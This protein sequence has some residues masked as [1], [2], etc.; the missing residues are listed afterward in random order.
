MVL[1]IMEREADFSGR[2]RWTGRLRALLRSLLRRLAQWAGL[3]MYC[4]RCQ[5]G[6]ELVDEQ[7]LKSPTPFL[8]RGV[9]IWRCLACGE[10]VR[11][12]FAYWDDM[13]TWAH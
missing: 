6:L 1:E 4:P 8:V 9:R 11:Q 10:V 7:H 3:K 5:A 2:R 13:S 12:P